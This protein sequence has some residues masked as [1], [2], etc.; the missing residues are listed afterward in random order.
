MRDR[1]AIDAELRLIAAS[2]KAAMHWGG[3]VSATERIDEL[4]DER[5]ESAGA[6]RP[7]S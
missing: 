1:D 6:D 2:R 4:L 5:L 7:E 3:Q